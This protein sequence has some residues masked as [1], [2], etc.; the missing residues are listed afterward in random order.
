MSDLASISDEE[1]RYG[2]EQLRRYCAAAP[3]DEEIAADVDLFVFRR[4][5]E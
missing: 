5:L 2:R 1:F 3:R 4:A